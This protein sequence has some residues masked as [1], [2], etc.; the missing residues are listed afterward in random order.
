MTAHQC[1]QDS[2]HHH[3][4]LEREATAA[5]VGRGPAYFI[6]ALAVAPL[7][8]RLYGSFLLLAVRM[9]TLVFHKVPSILL[10]LDV[11]I[12]LGRIWLVRS[13]G[14]LF[15]MKAAVALLV[16]QVLVQWLIVHS[17]PLADEQR[18]ARLRIVLMMTSRISLHFDLLI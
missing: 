8:I 13:P 12:V 18:A 4:A 9:V 1:L 7:I 14:I 10:I 16:D 5:T 3:A 6:V 15:L 2:E 17:I 11:V